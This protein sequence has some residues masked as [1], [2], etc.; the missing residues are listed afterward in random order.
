M[1]EFR[2]IELLVPPSPEEMDRCFRGELD[3]D[4]Q[5]F[6]RL[7]LALH[8]AVRLRFRRL[9]RLGHKLAR[10]ARDSQGQ[11]P[12]RKALW[13]SYLLPAGAF[14]VLVVAC[15]AALQ[16]IQPSDHSKVK[17]GSARFS[18]GQVSLGKVTKAYASELKEALR[19]VSQ[20][21][22][23][24]GLAKSSRGIPLST[25]NTGLRAYGQPDGRTLLIVVRDTLVDG[26]L[27]DL[28]GD[29]KRESEH[30]SM[31][32][33]D[34]AEKLVG[35]KGT[36]L[37]HDYFKRQ[38]E[39]HRKQAGTNNWAD[40]SPGYHA[41]LHSPIDVDGDGV[42]EY[43]LSLQGTLFFLT[44]DGQV[45]RSWATRQGLAG[46]I[47]DDL[48]PADLDGDGAVDIVVSLAGA[49][50][51]PE[52][53]QISQRAI[54]AYSTDGKELAAP[55][56]WPNYPKLDALRDFTGDGRTELLISTDL[57][58]NSGYE[59][60]TTYRG[61]PIT[62]KDEDGAL[63]LIGFEGVEPFIKW[64]P[65][66]QVLRPEPHTVLQ[67]L[68]PMGEEHLRVFLYHHPDGEEYGEFYDF[69]PAQQQLT[70]LGRLAGEKL[71]V[72]FRQTALV[73]APDGPL[74]LLAR[75]RAVQLVDQFFESK[76]S[77]PAPGEVLTHCPGLATISE[78]DGPL[79]AFAWSDEQASEL[80]AY[81]IRNGSLAAI[82]S[83]EF[84]QP[85]RL[86]LPLAT[87]SN[88]MPLLVL[89]NQAELWELVANTDEQL[90]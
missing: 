28:S 82:A 3:S 14:A 85:V 74:T 54:A 90:P 87:R 70:F 72:P 27:L 17:L 64:L 4:E 80:L 15:W 39:E 19:Q 83:A 88:R 16:L 38:N 35:P 9:E 42:P 78:P 44:A 20:T 24:S 21:L 32:L 89:T 86:V 58:G 50:Y 47:Y 25:T 53:P 43:P 12:P 57:P 56:E 5:F 51:L 22:G 41:K 79:R 33:W 84:D 63:A 66:P 45:R 68:R 2:I 76:D 81:E 26:F 8:P 36:R 65:D 69:C 59:V 62:L 75:A 49:Y 60:N 67:L 48:Q 40:Y 31:D 71:A 6:F 77:A 7:R 29:G 11:G 52:Y 73:S 23:P 55:L 10:H 30:W 1:R 61:A 13:R 46:W 37:A 18:L 34:S